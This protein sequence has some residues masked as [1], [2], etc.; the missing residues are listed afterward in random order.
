MCEYSLTLVER[1]TRFTITLWTANK[2]AATIR[3]AI[4][5]YFAAHPELPRR[6]ITFDYGREFA[7]HAEITKATGM[8]IYFATP[9]HSWERGLNENT[10]GLLRQYFPKSHSLT[11]IK[12]DLVLLTER[13]NNR[14]HRCLQYRTPSEALARYRPPRCSD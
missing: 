9:Y 6:S 3:N 8:K 7:E 14:P 11:D 10:N 4:N 12:N 5:A 2:E 13:L 1:K